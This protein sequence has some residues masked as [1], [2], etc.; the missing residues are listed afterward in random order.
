[1]ADLILVGLVVLI[2]LLMRVF[3][4]GL[5]IVPHSPEPYLKRLSKQVIYETVSTS[6]TEESG[7]VIM[8]KNEKSNEYWA[9][10]VEGTEAPP[11]RFTLI[12]GK[13]VALK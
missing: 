6:L 1:M 3:D 10:R 5:G 13:P 2:A 11:K 9:I 8:V 7:M 4:L 12:D